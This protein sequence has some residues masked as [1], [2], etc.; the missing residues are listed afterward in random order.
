MNREHATDA[1][2]ALLTLVGVFVALRRTRWRLSVP[3]ALG[4]V[5]ATLAFEYLA[6]RHQEPIRALWARPAVKGLTVVATFALV[7]GSTRTRSSTVLSALCGALVCYLALLAGVV[8][9]KLAH[10]TEW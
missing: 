6:S 7:V 1:S 9:G 10:P 4:G 2:L 8:T 5:L 3:S